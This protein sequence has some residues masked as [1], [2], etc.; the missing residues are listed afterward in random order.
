M[1]A[2]PSNNEGQKEREKKKKKKQC[3]AARCPEGVGGWGTDKGGGQGV[4]RHKSRLS[5]SYVFGS[6]HARVWASSQL[7]DVGWGWGWGDTQWLENG[8]IM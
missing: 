1:A 2:A 7:G 4:R 6:P 8:K 3:R 5:M